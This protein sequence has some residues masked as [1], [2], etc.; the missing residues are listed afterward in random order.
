MNRLTVIFVTIL[1]TLAVTVGA[2]VSLFALTPDLYGEG[3][4]LLYEKQAG[5]CSTGGGCAIVSKRE[6]SLIIGV[7]CSAEDGEQPAI[8]GRQVLLT[9]A[10]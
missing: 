6:M 1:A 8:N 3:M 4:L 2:A 10:P 5:E 7:A 9:S